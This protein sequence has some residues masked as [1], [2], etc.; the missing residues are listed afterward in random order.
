ME[1]L[2]LG[3]SSH[4]PTEAAE[5][6]LD[7]IIIGGGPAGSSA[8]I[9]TARAGLR[10]LVIDRALASG[11]LGIT[12]R[13]ANYPGLL[14]PVA[15]ADLVSTMR[16]QAE[17]FGARFI[18]AQVVGADIQGVTKKVY[19]GDDEY[20]A[21]ALIIASGALG[22]AASL[23][24][25]QALLG[26]GVS[27]CATCDAPFFRDKTVAVVGFNEE[28]A[29]EALHLAR[30]VR[31]VHFLSP[32]RTLQVPADLK[33]QLER[34]PQIEMS[35]GA[36][37][38]SIEGEGKVEGVRL[39]DGSFLPLQGV[40]LYLQGNR[41]ASEFLLGAVPVGDDGCLRAGEE[42]QTPVSGVF[43][44]GDVVCGH[45]KQAVV[46]AAD[47]AVAGMGVDRFLSGRAGLRSDWG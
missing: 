36:R 21:S 6:Q 20:Q 12:H 23:P 15:G 44:V 14:Q 3:M 1:S 27:Y 40:F 30:F 16:A 25:E 24:G 26:R 43:A 35:M 47:G 28:A 17:S 10:T 41:P 9:Y 32:K 45:V 31:K 42:G 19:A 22:R 11:A 13:I 46:A 34:L 38:R 29:A 7:V 33:G 18:Q 8:A 37:L 4:A 5:S 2:S 39:A